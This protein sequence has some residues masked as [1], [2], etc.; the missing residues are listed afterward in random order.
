MNEVLK[1]VLMAALIAAIPAGVALITSLFG[2]L[3]AWIEAK[4]KNQWLLIIERE[5]FDVVSYIGQTMIDPIET[6]RP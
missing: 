5:A 6:L 3:N 4:T 1:D 2:Y